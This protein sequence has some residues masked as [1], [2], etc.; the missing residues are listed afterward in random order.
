[1]NY[2]IVE[3]FVSIN[4]E[5]VKAGEL[6]VF[7]R[8][9]GCNL[10]CGY[11]D[12]KWANIPDAKSVSMSVKQIVDVVCQSG[13]DNVTLT[14]GEPLMQAGIEKVIAALLLNDKCVEIETNGSMDIEKIRHKVKAELDNNM[15]D[16]YYKHLYPVTELQYEVI[17]KVY[18]DTGVAAEEQIMSIVNSAEYKYNG[19][20]PK[21][22]KRTY[23]GKGYIG[24]NDVDCK[25][26]E[27][28]RW[29]NMIQRCYNKNVHKYKPYYKDKKVCEEWLNFANFRIW[30]REHIIEGAKVDLDK[31]ILCQ[32]NKVYSP[33]TC[34]F[35]EHYI[36]TIFERSVKRRIVQ[37]KEKQYEVYMIVLNK[38]ISFGKFDT[39]E[40]AEK[41]YITGKKDYILK[42]ADSCKGKVQDCLYNAMVNWNVGI[43]D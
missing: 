14:G 39:K 32:G 8:F 13:V 38:N 1:M 9:K 3:H 15:K 5:G 34:V 23:E 33:E 41:G 28:Q 12:T 17:K 35:V 10:N 18:D 4:G 2:N 11:C 22:F 43:A 21:C 36:N 27:Y 19:W 42:L 31:D 40:E 37:N 30:Y 29:T 26:P 7:V 25:S 6:A 16:N 24:T 20:N